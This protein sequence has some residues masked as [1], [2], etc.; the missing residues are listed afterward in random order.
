MATASSKS[1]KTNEGSGNAS[2]ASLEADI[3]QLREDVSE[4]ARL[5]KRTGGHA[6]GTAR[7]AASASA[8][9]MR[10]QG[11]AAMEGLRGNAKEMEEQFES[12]IRRKP[13]T[14]VAMAA[15]VGF[16]LAVM[17]RN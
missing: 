17:A 13:L 3:A 2:E 9:D 1:A 10:S 12:A 14:A 6:S 11:E 5:L 7:R 16:L 15:G 4:L 8:D